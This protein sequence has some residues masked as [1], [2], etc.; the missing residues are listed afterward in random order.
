MCMVF[1]D[2][3]FFVFVFIVISSYVLWVNLSIYIC[4]FVYVWVCVCMFIKPAKISMWLPD[5]DK[6]IDNEVLD[7]NETRLDKKRKEETTE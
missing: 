5:F 4:A 2:I 1:S 7:R 6:Y 3:Y